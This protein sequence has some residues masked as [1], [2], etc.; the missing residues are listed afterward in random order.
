MA[1]IGEEGIDLAILPIGDYYTMGPG[2]R[3]PG[4]Q[5]V[6]P[7]F[8]LPIHYNT[9][10]RHRAGRRCLGGRVKS[11]TSAQPVVLQPGDWFEIPKTDRSAFH[12]MDVRF[13]RFSR[14]LIRAD[15][16]AE[17]SLDEGD[18]HRGGSIPGADRCRGDGRDGDP[19]ALGAGRGAGAEVTI[20]RGPSP[21][22]GS[23]SS[24]LRW[25]DRW[26]ITRRASRP[27][28]N[29]PW[30]R[31]GWIGWPGRARRWRSW[32]TTRRA[33]RRSARPCRS[34]CA[35][36]CG[37]RPGRGRDD[38]RR[39]GSAPCRRR[40][41]RC[42]AGRRGAS[43]PAIDASARR[44]TTS[45]PMPIS[46]GRRQ[47]IPVR[48]FRPV[49]EADLRILI[50]SVLPHLQAGFGG[51]YKLI[52]PGTSHRTTLGALHR[53]G[54]DGGSDAGGLLGGDAAANPMRRAIHAAAEL[55]GPCWSIS[56]LIG[57]PGQI[58]RVIAGHPDA[59]RTC[60]ADEA[61]RRFRAPTS[62]AGRRGRGGQSSLAGRP[63]A[64]LQGAASSPRG[65]P[66][67]RRAGRPV[68]DRPRGDR[69]LVPRLGA[70]ADRRDG[71][72]GRPGDPPARADRPAGRRG[73]RVAG[74]VHDPLG[75]RAGRR[76]HRAGLCP[77]AAR[78]DRPPPRADR[79][80]RRSGRA[81]AGRLGFGRAR[82]EPGDVSM[83]GSS[84]KAD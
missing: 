61:R 46:A 57:G 23:M 3:P 56:H 58:F 25:T 5:A 2:R 59:S 77:A 24:G 54:L 7:R 64:E 67:G 42:A 62:C 33:G 29:R 22:R 53:Q 71:R 41:R 75:P 52:F 30:A 80:F 34:C 37:R 27:P 60:L 8:V 31:I 47:G 76:P 4:R 17:E 19:G 68:L 39:G 15:D 79:A 55:L 70:A 32:W 43:P 74:R 72:L 82:S 78:P 51:G 16:I 20:R 40:R 21:G 44:W 11:E 6:K 49:A 35:A 13:G 45:P 65:L 50:G 12:G 73:G 83:S 36:A 48:V 1:L 38:Q 9:F 14:S 28:W 18:A 10:P 26:P 66:A 69:P 63:D 84:R 81:V